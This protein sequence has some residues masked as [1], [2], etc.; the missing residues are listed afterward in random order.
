MLWHFLCAVTGLSLSSS[1]C[2]DVTSHPHTN[3]AL[4]RVLT[5]VEISRDQEQNAHSGAGTVPGHS[6][7]LCS[8][9]LKAL[10][11][12]RERT[13]FSLFI[14]PEKTGHRH[15]TE[16]EG[17]KQPCDALVDGTRHFAPKYMEIQSDAG[18]QH[19]EEQRAD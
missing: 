19:K 8:F 10:I 12:L 3:T 14:T 5:Y 9:T 17:G 7:M 6:H 15:R 2:L 4:T 13:C 11:Y 1:W 16:T 18:I